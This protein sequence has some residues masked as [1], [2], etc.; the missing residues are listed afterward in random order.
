M[1]AV[2]KPTKSQ[3]L[4]RL[5]WRHESGI[6]SEAQLDKQLREELT[7]LQRL[8]VKWR[9]TLRGLGHRPSGL[10]ERCDEAINR[11]L[12]ALN[13]KDYRQ[14]LKHLKET[15]K[16]LALLRELMDDFEE[17]D[18]AMKAYAQLLSLLNS[19][20]LRELP[21]IKTIAH[22]F[23]EADKLLV[24]GVTETNW[25]R[26]SGAGHQARFIAR[27]CKE[28]V[29]TLQEK[30]S[31]DGAEAQRLLARIKLQSAFCAQTEAFAPSPTV[32]SKLRSALER[33]PQLLSERH[34]TLVG[35]LTDDIEC[36][37][38][39]RRAVLATFRRYLELDGRSNRATREVVEE[40]KR[41]IRGES[42]GQA[43]TY[44][45]QQMLTAVSVKA[46]ALQ[47]SIHRTA[48]KLE[49]INKDGARLAAETGSNIS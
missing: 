16:A 27:L 19:E 6:Y 13:I 43:A 11:A 23:A 22:L 12:S 44:L 48:Q 1:R 3:E 39:S 8:I 10:M 31:G 25:M 28:K 42:W 40:V 21:S 20:H 9:P 15:Q 45:L 26:A 34:L 2:T 41:I 49:D 7:R 33:L 37:L 30:T 5:I 36:E 35:R 14:G 38:A 18:S 24:A 29:L 17:Y 46:S 47:L 32:D 4:A